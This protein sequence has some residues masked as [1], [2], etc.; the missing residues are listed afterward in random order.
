MT[1]PETS[2]VLNGSVSSSPRTV[3]APSDHS[4]VRRRSSTVSEVGEHTTRPRLSPTLIRTYNPLDPDVRERQR[5]MDADM[6]IQLSRARSS[7]PSPTAIHPAQTSPVISPARHIPAEDHPQYPNLSA[8]EEH[9]VH[10]IRSSEPRGGGSPDIDST[11]VPPPQF[12]A[13]PTS[14]HDPHFNHLSAAHDPGLLVALDS[15]PVEDS[16]LGG[17]PMYQPAVDRQAAPQFDF[18]HM[19]EFAREE[20]VRLGLLT[21][22]TDRPGGPGGGFDF[23]V[24]SAPAARNAASSSPP[25]P[26]TQSTSPDA[27][28]FPSTSSSPAPSEIPFALPLPR[29]RHRKLSHSNPHPRRGKLALFEQPSAPPPALAARVPHL[30][31]TALSAV[32]SYDN[33]VDSTSGGVGGNGPIGGGNAGLA[34]AMNLAIGTGI[35][36]GHDRPYRF[37]FYS[38]ALSATIHA[39]SLSELPAEGQSFEDLF[40]GRNASSTDGSKVRNGGGAGGVNGPGPMSPPKTPAFNAVDRRDIGLHGAHSGLANE[41]A[42]ELC[43]WWLDV[44]SPTD[45]EM[46]LL[47]KV[48]SPSHSLVFCF[49]LRPWMIERNFTFRCSISIR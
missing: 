2:S 18:T 26:D 8:Q 47:S 31:G 38:N 3:R 30:G 5:T 46:K 49:Y 43:T 21:P 29:T 9:D 6:A 19:E 17:L 10:A 11:G 34:R 35:G 45:E 14:D 22:V 40:F 32:P 24:R 25:P 37:S 42:S 16:G 23:R 48:R 41:G 7:I 1:S 33:L 36:N 4:P 27:S 15:A 12:H 39:R 20:K 44:L 28:A 13:G